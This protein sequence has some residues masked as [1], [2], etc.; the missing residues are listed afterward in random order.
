MN[1]LQQLQ[2]LIYQTILLGEIINGQVDMA[3]TFHLTLPE[4]QAGIP[5][6]PDTYTGTTGTIFAR[7]QS[8]IPGFEDCYD[9][10][11]LDLIV[12][13]APAIADPIDDYPLCDNDQDGTEDFDLITWGENEIL[14]GLTDVT[15]TYYNI[16]ADADLG[17]PVNEIPTSSAYNSAGAEIIWVRA[18]NL[19]LC[20]TVSSFNLEL[21]IPFLS[22]QKFLY[23]KFVMTILLMVLQNLTLKVRL[24]SLLLV[25][26]TL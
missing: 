19:N 17:D 21:Q 25:T 7:L 15:L 8:T 2:S 24:Q 22:I 4:A 12:N 10:I 3:V 5:V 11:E 9:V 18:V 14:N 1:F 6:L 23:F 13:P 20:V 16:Q 26:L